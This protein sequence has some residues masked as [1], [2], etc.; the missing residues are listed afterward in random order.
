MQEL[1]RREQ[2]RRGGARRRGFES[3]CAARA[4][5]RRPSRARLA[6]YFR[7]TLCPWRW[8]RPRSRRWRQVRCE[9]AAGMDSAA[10]RKFGLGRIE[11]WGAADQAV[12]SRPVL[13]GREA[14]AAC[15]NEFPGLAISACK[16]RLKPCSVYHIAPAREATRLIRSALRLHRARGPSA[17]RGALASHRQAISREPRTGSRKRS[18]RLTAAEASG[19]NCEGRLRGSH[20][21][22]VVDGST[23]IQARCARRG[24]KARSKRATRSK[25]ARPRSR[26]FVKALPEFHEDIAARR[27]RRDRSENQVDRADRR[28]LLERLARARA[29]WL[30]LEQWP[31]SSSPDD[32]CCRSCRQLDRYIGARLGARAPLAAAEATLD[33]LLIRD[34]APRRPRLCRPGKHF[35]PAPIDAD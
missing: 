10:R 12:D 3:S 7:R 9:G 14:W 26:R 8:A 19:R 1:R 33:R 17:G 23:T 2:T 22:S 6:T 11:A 30:G 16:R 29:D 21:R 32:A 24:A 20:R 4:S 35:A 28:P 31:T 5:T 18:E 34:R 27:D 25:R 13:R 15:S